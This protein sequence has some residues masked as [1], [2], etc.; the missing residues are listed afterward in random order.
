MFFIFEKKKRMPRPKKN[1]S[2]TADH[3]GMRDGPSPELIQKGLDTINKVL[4]PAPVA[5]A[6]RA[7]A[8]PP[9]PSVQPP[10]R[11]VVDEW[12]LRDHPI[13][14]DLIPGID[15]WETIAART[16]RDAGRAVTR[17]ATNAGR[18]V[19]GAGRAAGAGRVVAGAGRV[20]AGAGRAAGAATGAAEAVGVAAGETLA[21]I[22][23]VIGLEG[24]AAMLAGGGIVGAVALATGLLIYGATVLGKRIHNKFKAAHEKHGKE[25]ALAA[26]ARETLSNVNLREKLEKHLSPENA[27][28]LNDH[29]PLH[30]EVDLGS[31]KRKPVRTTTEVYKGKPSYVYK[32]DVE[33]DDEDPEPNEDP[34][35]D[36]PDEDYSPPTI[37]NMHVE[38]RIPDISTKQITIAPNNPYVP[39]TPAPKITT[40]SEDNSGS[41]IHNTH[42]QY[43]I[44][45]TKEI[46]PAPKTS[47]PKITTP[48]AGQDTDKQMFQPPEKEK[49]LPQQPRQ[50]FQD[51]S[52]AS[53]HP[54]S[55]Q[56]QPRLS[57]SDYQYIRQRDPGYMV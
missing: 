20:V 18:A 57:A 45:D 51:N 53:I 26:L 29:I 31:D 25:A 34:E 2:Y 30:T 49:P 44:P 14:D 24:G 17:A 9:Y 52:T 54:M 27:Q 35:P 39:K 36:E 40:P 22:G 13:E 56:Q 48:S 6:G 1:T 7:V 12:W 3:V 38:N 37:H 46:I 4:E 42:L 19:A 8:R 16:A 23:G 55:T 15:S 21:G 10:A 5:A 11:P 28:V 41:T 47:A 43:R 32:D 50:S 33:F